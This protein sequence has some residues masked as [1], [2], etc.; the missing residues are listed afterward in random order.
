MNPL[1]LTQSI[2]G[3]LAVLCV[4]ATLHP[5]LLLRRGKPLSRRNVWAIAAATVTTLS[6]FALGLGIYGDYR[7]SVKRA[8]FAESLRSG[9]LF[10]TKEHLAFLVLSL[11]IGAATTALAAPRSRS[12]LRQA[13]ALLFALAALGGAITGA[14]GASVAAV[15]SFAG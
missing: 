14:L 3:Y 7:A 13:A 9:L 10:E 2:H 5:A 11:V 12:D 6:T 4:A 8:L 1:A 15:R